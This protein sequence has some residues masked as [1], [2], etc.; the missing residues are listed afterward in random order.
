MMLHASFRLG[1]IARYLRIGFEVKAVR[2]MP[3]ES[4]FFTSVAYFPSKHVLC[5]KFHSGEIYCYF[6]F[7][8]EQ[9]KEFLGADSKGQYFA[10]D[11]RDRFRYL[12]ISRRQG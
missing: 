2:W 5:L 3:L 11:I 8:P 1:C 4:S 6:D 10:R 7:S 12:R 9:Y